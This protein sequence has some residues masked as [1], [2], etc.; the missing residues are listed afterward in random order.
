MNMRK[1]SKEELKEILA[2]H[3]MWLEDNEKGTKADL[4]RANL[5]GANLRYAD[6]SDTDLSGA[7]L[8]YANLIGA[9]LRFADLSDTD[10]SGA[11]LRNVN[12][13]CAELS[14][15]NLSNVYTSSSTAFYHLQC[16][17]TGSFIG[18]KKAQGKI[19]KLKILAD[20]KRSSA[21]TRKCRCD[22]ALVLGIYDENKSLSDIQEV[23]SNYDSN[24][25]Y[26]V[27]EVVEE[28]NFDTDRWK[29]YTEGIHFFITFEE[30]KNC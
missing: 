26:K 7:N 6:L 13:S 10:L 2:K 20:A 22:K 1:L 19:I 8:R 16:P 18:Y 21:T 30:A 27:G 12:L 9:N 4:R 11:D 17:E 3:K 5:I 29:E 14:G 28:P 24:F 15:V 25:I 23:A